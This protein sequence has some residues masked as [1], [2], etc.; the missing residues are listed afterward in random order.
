MATKFKA[1]RQ[2]TKPQVSLET[3]DP[4]PSMRNPT[5]ALHLKLF[6]SI[7]SK[8]YKLKICD[9]LCN[10]LNNISI[11]ENQNNVYI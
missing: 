3:T 5:S 10:I 9:N 8:D 6:K 7:R 11:T 4:E 1:K 2:L